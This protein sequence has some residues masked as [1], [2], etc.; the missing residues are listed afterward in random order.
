M[1]AIIAYMCYGLSLRGEKNSYLRLGTERP[2]FYPYEGPLKKPTGES[3]EMG[4][5][6]QQLSGNMSTAN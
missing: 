2:H 5:S 4:A 1:V 3:G 6:E